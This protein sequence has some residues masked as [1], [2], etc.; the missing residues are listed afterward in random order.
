MKK[1]TLIQSLRLKGNNISEYFDYANEVYNTYKM[2]ILKVDKNKYKYS[3]D[4]LHYN[5]STI[6]EKMFDNED[7]AKWEALTQ[8]DIL[9][10]VLDK[11]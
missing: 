8:L 6:V 9:V 11:V 1:E 10:N 5:I 2:C 3:I 7:D 4:D